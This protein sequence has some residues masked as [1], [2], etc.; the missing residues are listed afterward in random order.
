MKDWKWASVKGWPDRMIAARSH[1][2]SSVIESLAL[3][4]PYT[5]FGGVRAPTFVEVGLVEVVGPGNVHVVE[6]GDLTRSGQ[7]VSQCNRLRAGH[8][9]HVAVP[10]EVLEELDLAQSALGEDLLAEDIGD[11]LDGDAFVGCGVDSGARL[12]GVQCML[13]DVAPLSVRCF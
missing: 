12:G 2:M 5:G 1:S 4:S 6:A 3:C 13:A 11:L 9:T 7:R 10:P 8:A